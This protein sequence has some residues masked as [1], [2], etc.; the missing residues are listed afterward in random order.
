M[1][2][3][4]DLFLNARHPSEDPAA[5]APRDIIMVSWVVLSVLVGGSGALSNTEDASP[6]ED[7]PELL[8]SLQ[9]HLARAAGL[10]V[11]VF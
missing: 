5:S 10:M 2:A 11:A 6:Y 9:S 1:A 4:L 7:P 3:L 8:H